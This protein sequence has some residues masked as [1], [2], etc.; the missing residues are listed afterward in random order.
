MQIYRRRVKVTKREYFDGIHQKLS[1]E[2]GISP[3]LV[4]FIRTLAIG[5]R[6]SRGQI[7]L[8]CKEKLFVQAPMLKK[9]YQIIKQHECEHCKHITKIPSSTPKPVLIEKAV[10]GKTAKYKET[11]KFMERADEQTWKDITFEYRYGGIA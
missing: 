2:F 7:I 6:L 11:I 1:E 10:S 5:R 3:L 9:Q 8:L 4:E